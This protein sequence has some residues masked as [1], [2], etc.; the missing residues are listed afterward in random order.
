MLP[1]NLF[2]NTAQTF[3]VHTQKRGDVLHGNM[4]ENFGMFVHQF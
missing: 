1:N 3:R 4:L 2:T